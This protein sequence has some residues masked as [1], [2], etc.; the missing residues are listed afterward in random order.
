ME[1]KKKDEILQKTQDQFEREK[2]GDGYNS[3]R[4]IVTYELD[5]EKVKTEVSKR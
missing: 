3:I 1:Q 4:V 5:S 2:W